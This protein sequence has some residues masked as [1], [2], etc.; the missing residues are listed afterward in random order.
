MKPEIL[1][2]VRY[3][4]EQSTE[5]LAAAKLS[6]ENGLLR[7]SVNR[8]YYACFY[9]VSALLL[10][11][12]HRASKHSGVRALFDRYWIKPRRLPVKMAQFYRDVFKHRHQGDYEHLVSFTRDEVEEWLEEA[13]TFIAKISEEIEKLL[14]SD[15]ANTT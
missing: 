6:L 11:E 10:C 12:D 14:D 15:Q 2:Y 7:S 4:T 1:E 3:R 13:T 9:V 5:A 8:L